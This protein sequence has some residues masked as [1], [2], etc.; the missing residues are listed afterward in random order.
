MRQLGGMSRETLAGHLGDSD[1]AAPV[2]KPDALHARNRALLAYWRMVRGDAAIPSWSAFDLLKISGLLPTLV[3]LERSGTDDFRYRFAGPR[4]VT[5]AGLEPTGQTVADLYGRGLNGD[6]VRDLNAALVERMVYAMHVTYGSRAGR[7]IAIEELCLPLSGDTGTPR[8]VLKGC[9]LVDG[10]LAGG[11][12]RDHL[13][14]KSRTVEA[15][16]AV[17]TAD[18]A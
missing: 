14:L 15:H 2:L 16:A 13:M 17:L 8:F 9:Q 10:R 7:R 11:E 5:R 18:R 3:L 6:I 4:I 1:K 12:P